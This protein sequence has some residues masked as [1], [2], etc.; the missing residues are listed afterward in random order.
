MKKYNLEYSAN[1]QIIKMKN[2]TMEQAE[3]FIKGLPI[4]NESSL[5]LK[6][7]KEIEKEQER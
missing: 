7:I 1:G 3:E 5:I 4:V 6:E 2:I